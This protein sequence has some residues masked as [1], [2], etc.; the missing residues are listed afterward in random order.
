MTF[1]TEGIVFFTNR[2]DPRYAWHFLT[3]L[4]KYYSRH[5]IIPTLDLL[6][7]TNLQANKLV[8]IGYV[9]PTETHYKPTA[10]HNFSWLTP[11]FGWWKHHLLRLNR[12]IT[13]ETKQPVSPPRAHDVNRSGASRAIYSW[14]RI[15]LDPRAKTGWD[16]GLGRF[17][18]H[19]KWVFNARYVHTIHVHSMWMILSV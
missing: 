18:Y 1:Q 10:N 9:H 2:V 3:H 12:H 15:N 19:G 4:R 13:G 17:F 14:L 11:D 7:H 5:I 16:K 6:L 8:Q